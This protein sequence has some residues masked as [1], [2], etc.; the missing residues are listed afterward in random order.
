MTASCQHRL[1]KRKLGLPNLTA[2]YKEMIGS[3]D[4]ERALDTVDLDFSKGF[5]IVSCNILTD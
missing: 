3:L 2:F 1:T 4:K 5:N